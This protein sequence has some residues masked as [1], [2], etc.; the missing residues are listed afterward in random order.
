MNSQVTILKNL[1]L[2]YNKVLFSGIN[3]IAGENELIAIVGPNGAGKSTLLKSMA[4]LIPTISGSIEIVGRNINE[5]S[6]KKIASVLSFVP[7]QSQRAYN[8]SLY[9]MIATGSYN[10][11]NWLGSLSKEENHKID[12]IIDK[13]GLT[14]LKNSDSSTLSDGEYQRA[15]IARSLVQDSKIILLDEPTAFLDIENKAIITKLLSR[16]SHEEG[17]TIIFS[18]HDLPLAINM[19]D[20]I[21]ILGYYGFFEGTPEELIKKGAFDKMFKDSGLRFNPRAL[22]LI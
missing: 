17:K 13:L 4:A 22:T 19:C 7:S 1:S 8:L 20:K 21:W 5:Y 15:A 6:A 16:I 10:R 18:T 2:G 12:E 11:T 9:D 14:H 3:A